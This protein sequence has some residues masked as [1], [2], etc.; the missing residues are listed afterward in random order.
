LRAEAAEKKLAAI[1]S[2]ARSIAQEARA[3]DVKPRWHLRLDGQ[4]VYGP[5]DLPVVLDWVAQCR[6]APQDEVSADGQSWKR[7]DGVP[8]LRMDW[9]VGLPDGS[10]YG[11]VNLQAVAQMI[12]DGIVAPNAPLA[13]KITGQKQTADWLLSPEI[14]AIRA[15]LEQVQNEKDEMEKE[16]SRLR[17][18]L[19]DLRSALTEV[20]LALSAGPQAQAPTPPMPPRSVKAHL[21]KLGHQS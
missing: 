20:T 8:E 14:S 10:T 6:V 17:A 4:S 3:A 12:K 1:A 5:V 19:A 9:L 7:A 11:P 15:E 2:A 18:D 16:V 13:H 21:M